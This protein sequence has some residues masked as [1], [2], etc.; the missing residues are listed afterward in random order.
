[1]AM[2]DAQAPFAAA[3]MDGAGIGRDRG[4]ASGERRPGGTFAPFRRL[5]E[6]AAQ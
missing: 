3:G 6:M 2:W 5:V 1:M 4:H